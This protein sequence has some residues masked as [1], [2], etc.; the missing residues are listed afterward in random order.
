[1]Q[2]KIIHLHQT[3]ST[4]DYLRALP[5]PQDD[6]MTVVYADWQTAGRGQGSNKWE[7]EKGKNLLFS[8]ITPTLSIESRKQFLISMAM[9]NAIYDVLVD[10]GIK[11]VSIKWPNDIYAGNYKISG[12]LIENRLAG[13]VI[14]RSIIGVGLNV[15]QSVFISDAPNPTSMTILTGKQYDLHCIMDGIIHN[16]KRM[17]YMA[18]SAPDILKIMYMERMYRKDGMHRY[19]DRNGSFLASSEGVTD[20]GCL[21]LKDE[22]GNIRQYGFKEVAF[23]I[24]F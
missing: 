15:N 16:F 8:I 14:R 19:Y 11:G 24:E 21:M 6:C 7:S 20:S 5:S 4:N 1:M 9:A 13:C 18:S 23:D 3:A 17:T 10:N 22:S 12:T 2:H